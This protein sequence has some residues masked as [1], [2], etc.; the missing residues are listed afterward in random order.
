M[1]K[2]PV[3]IKGSDLI[4]KLKKVYGY[5]KVHQVGSHI[6]LKIDGKQPITIP[7]HN[8]V[9]KGTLESI[10]AQLATYQNKSYDTVQAEL[11]EI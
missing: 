9:R 6:K 2:I 7:D 5:E 1:A 4:K 8:P 10:I 11:G 3:N